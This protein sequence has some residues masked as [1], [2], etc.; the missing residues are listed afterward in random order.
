MTR[1]AQIHNGKKGYHNNECDLKTE[2]RDTPL[3]RQPIEVV[4]K[5]NA[6]S[7]KIL[8]L[9]ADITRNVSLSGISTRL[10]ENHD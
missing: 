6:I 5:E 9:T 4:F 2:I 8:F 10:R 1:R 7:F 3:A